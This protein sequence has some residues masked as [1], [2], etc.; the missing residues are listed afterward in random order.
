MTIP[1]KCKNDEVLIQRVKDLL[2]A[3]ATQLY[4]DSGA[5]VSVAQI[6]AHLRWDYQRTH[7]HVHQAL[8]AGLLFR[9]KEVRQKNEKRLTIIG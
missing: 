2:V 8:Q 5:P 7:K 9:E 4:R 3:A 1:L 6:S